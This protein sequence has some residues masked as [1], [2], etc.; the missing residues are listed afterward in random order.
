MAASTQARL[1]AHGL[2]LPDGYGIATMAE[3]PDT[4]QAVDAAMAA[5]WP[6]FMRHD[7]VAGSYFGRADRDWPDFQL[8]LTDAAGQFVAVAN[9][10]PLRWDGTDDDLPEG[11]IDQGR[12]GVADRDAGR[13]PDALGAMQIVVRPDLHGGGLSGTMIE[14]MKAAARS[15]GFRAVIACLRPTWKDRYPLAPMDRYAWWT[16]ADGQPF[17]PWIRLHVRLGAR[18]ARASPRSMPMRGTVA[19]WEDWTGMV[20]PDSGVYVVPR[21]TGPVEIDRERDLGVHFDQNVWVVHDV[22]G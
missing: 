21:A 3:N 15:A 18:I 11:W 10:M 4:E 13:A 7:P 6:E 16:R 1:E 20:F 14:A 12:R 22:R 19:D 17:D 5:V 9:S 8:V 2:R